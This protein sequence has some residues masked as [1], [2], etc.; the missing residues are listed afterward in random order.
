[1]KA[2]YP[3]IDDFV[4]AGT[5]G[6][7]ERL[8]ELLAERSSPHARLRGRPRREGVGAPRRLA[9]VARLRGGGRRPDAEAPRSLDHPAATP[10]AARPLR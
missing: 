9:G 2:A 4:A 10:N 5:L 6:S 3:F 7:L 1:M 8:G